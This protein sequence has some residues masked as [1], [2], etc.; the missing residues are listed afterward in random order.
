LLLLMLSIRLLMSISYS[1]GR[2]KALKEG[3]AA[4]T[5]TTESTPIVVK[6]LQLS[7]KKKPEITVNNKLATHVKNTAGTTVFT[8]ETIN[9]KLDYIPELQ[10]KVSW[11][12]SVA[13]TSR[14]DSGKDEITIT[15]KENKT[16]WPR[17]AY[18]RFKDKR[19]LNPKMTYIKTADGKSELTVKLLQAGNPN[20]KVRLRWVK[21]VHNPTDAEKQAVPITDNGKPTDQGNFDS[22]YIFT[23]PETVNSGFFNIR[24]LSVIRQYAKQ[25]DPLPPLTIEG[26]SRNYTD[27]NQCWAKS[28]SNVLH[29]WFAQNKE[30]I[31][32]Y[33]DKKG[34]TA[35][36]EEAAKYA[37]SYTPCLPDEQEN[38]KSS[39]ANFFRKECGDGGSYASQAIRW[40][41]IDKSS[42]GKTVP[43]L[44][45]DVFNI[46][47][48]PLNETSVQ[49]K[50]E[51]EQRLN[52]AFDK[53]EAIL[54]ALGNNAHDYGHAITCWGAAYDELD[55]IICI[56][57][58]A[59]NFRD[60]VLYPFGI[61]YEKDLE[62]TGNAE[63][64]QAYIIYYHNNTKPKRKITFVTSLGTGKD[65]FENWLSK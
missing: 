45:K 64:N 32:R 14:N 60:N 54:L 35:G 13:I 11:I 10:Q 47:T 39:I 38:T 41:L 61:D 33:M 5:I 48:I 24:K 1:I 65:Q 56:Y 57:V 21:G 49:T 4:I 53:G 17:T 55:N 43:S 23:Y 9:G 7:I 28:A 63:E 62:R 6:T 46:D 12:E 15:C 27:M 26:N 40:Y 25:G 18:I 42:Y 34:I 3:S 20:P 22:S 51:F 29:W 44:F 59:S 50:A 37:C 8:V 2:I 58:S 52:D 16:V 30:L 36:S 31:K 19:P